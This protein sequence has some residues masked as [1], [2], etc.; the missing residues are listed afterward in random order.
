MEDFGNRSAAARS[1]PVASLAYS[2]AA[3]CGSL[4]ANARASSTFW[5]NVITVR[6]PYAAACSRSAVCSRARRRPR[7]ASSDSPSTG[8]VADLQDVD[9]ESG[10]DLPL[11]RLRQPE[12]RQPRA[13]GAVRVVGHGRELR[14]L[15]VHTPLGPGRSENARRGGGTAGSPPGCGR[16]RGWRPR[17]CPDRRR[18]RGP[19]PRSRGRSLP[20]AGRR[21][22]LRPPERPPAAREPF[23]GRRVRRCPRG[24]PGRRTWRTRPRVGPGPQG[25]VL[26]RVRSGPHAQLVQHRVVF[27]RAQRDHR[28]P[29]AH[30]PPRLGGLREQ[31]QGRDGDEDPAVCERLQRARGGR[32]GLARTGR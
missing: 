18:F 27:Q 8:R 29:V 21:A 23:A 19:H 2:S 7:C 14:F 16:C 11:D 30:G 31:V 4:S 17:A 20:S 12:L 32:D 1:A 25:E 28:R 10:E 9:L 3:V 22:V 5:W 13:V 26:D 6:R 15:A 24:P